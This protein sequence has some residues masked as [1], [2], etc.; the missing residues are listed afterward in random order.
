MTD[1]E[2]KAEHDRLDLLIQ[3]EEKRWEIDQVSK[4]MINADP[5]FMVIKLRMLIALVKEKFD[6]SEGEIDIYFKEAALEQLTA[7]RKMVV[8]ARKN[9][10]QQPPPLHLPFQ[11]LLGPNGRPL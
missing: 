10:P 5:Y 1:D 3:Q 11:G 9:M 8:K 2:I 6:L 7:D 4:N